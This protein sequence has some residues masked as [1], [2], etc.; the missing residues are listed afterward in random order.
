MNKRGGRNISVKPLTIK[1]YPFTPHDEAIFEAGKEMLIDSVKIGR[2]FC[3]HMISIST[4][5]IPIYLGLLV[6]GVSKCIVLNLWGSI[7]MVLPALLFVVS[8]VLFVIGYFPQKSSLSLEDLSL[9]KKERNRILLRR[10]RMAWVG[11]SVFLAGTVS[12][13][14]SIVLQL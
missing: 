2:D 10:Q 7:L 6:L 13:I 14:T 5:A 4:G 9:I 8:S 3:K 1:G 11:F 12:A